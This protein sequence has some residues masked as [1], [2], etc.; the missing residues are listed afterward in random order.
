MKTTRNVSRLLT[1]ILALCLMVALAAPAMAAEKNAVTDAKNAVMQVQIWF[2]DPAHLTADLHLLNGTG[3]LINGNTLVTNEH[4]VSYKSS[5][6]V[7]T[8]WVLYIN[9]QTGLQYTP[10]EVMDHMSIRVAVLRDVYVEASITTVSREM[11]YAVLTLNQ[12]IRNRTTLPIRS[13]S[14][15]KQTEAV[16]ALGYPGDYEDLVDQFYYNGEDVIITSGNVNNVGISS[17]SVEQEMFTSTFTNRIENVTIVEHSAKIV[18]GNSG[19]PLLDADGAVVGIN[20]HGDDLR[21]LAIASDELTATLDALGI[22]YEKAGLPAPV[23]TEPSEEPPVTTAATEAPPATTVATE[24]PPVTTEATVES[25]EPI[26]NDTDSDSDSNLTV[27][28]IVAAVAILAVVIVVVVV[29]SRGKKST[30]PVSGGYTPPA[31]SAAPQSENKGFQ[32]APHTPAS[33]GAAT[34]TGETTVLTKDAGETTVL[35]RNGGTLTRKRTGETVK[36]NM[37]HFVIGRERKTAN[38]CIT[39]NSSISRSH[40]TLTIRNGV[41][42]LTDMGTANGTFV[43]G[44][45]VIPRQEIALKNGDKITLADEDFE[46]KI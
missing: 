33:Y 26:K 41:T 23:P 1:L 31:S 19:G 10:E 12:E 9:Q 38:Y 20:A 6:E 29:V 44:V 28:L 21:N 16:Y 25:T 36:I 14:T 5:P 40:V 22:D 11:D 35:T 2:S 27:I 7:A 30:H 32:P 18:E 45:K 3:F 37:D 8:D 43:N 24:A 13:S 42:Y 34:D 15:L 17:Y 46:F 4:V 39:D